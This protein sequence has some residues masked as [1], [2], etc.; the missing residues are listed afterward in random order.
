MAEQRCAILVMLTGM[1]IAPKTSATGSDAAAENLHPSMGWAG[2]MARAQDG[3]GACYRALLVA[4]TPYLR[5]LAARH[6]AD[7][8]DVEDSV[9]D[10]LLTL[11]T[12]RHTYDPGR[13]FQPWLLAVARRRIV[14]RLRAQRRRRTRETFLDA[15]HETFAVTA[16]NQ[17]EGGPDARSLRAAVERLP[18]AQREAVTMLKLKEMSLKEAEAASGMSVMALKVATHRAMKN[19]RRLL[20]EKRQ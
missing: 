9:Q 8:R 2:L 15:E 6:H 12:I 4:I 17:E 14:D 11:H 16:A 13:P 1:T 5:A 10:I 18:P 7:R 19:L 20:G 3:D